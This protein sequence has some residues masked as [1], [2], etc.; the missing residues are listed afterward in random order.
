ML[1]IGG[2]PVYTEEIGLSFSR[3][4]Y[5]VIDAMYNVVYSSMLFA[6][7]YHCYLEKNKCEG[8]V[9]PAAHLGVC[10]L[11]NSDSKVF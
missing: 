5:G 3:N 8:T 2:Q 7:K 9:I 11:C 10:R 6:V 1:I 4:L